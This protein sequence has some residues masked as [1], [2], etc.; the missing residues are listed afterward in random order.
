[1][2]ACLIVLQLAEIIF[3]LVCVF[4]VNPHWDQTTV[5]NTGVLI[6]YAQRRARFLAL[7]R[8]LAF[9]AAVGRSNNLTH[10][11]IPASSMHCTFITVLD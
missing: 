8:C 5:Q 1:M 6:V 7:H 2:V 3:V 10:L 4:T 9:H 11:T